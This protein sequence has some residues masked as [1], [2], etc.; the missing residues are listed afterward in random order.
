MWRWR[1]HVT[2]RW[3]PLI[4]FYQIPRFDFK[5]F[6]LM[7]LQNVQNYYFENSP[8]SLSYLALAWRRNKPKF[9]SHSLQAKIPPHFNASVSS[10]VGGSL[11]K[12]EPAHH[13]V[14]H[15]VALQLIPIFLTMVH[16]TTLETFTLNRH[17]KERKMNFREEE[18]KLLYK[19][20][21]EFY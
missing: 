19:Y 15:T 2:E 7:L 11:S 1:F 17:K 14:W 18:H 13:G 6:I 10:S 20:M 12:M 8:S 16:F 5:L 4:A 3:G 21:W 9:Q